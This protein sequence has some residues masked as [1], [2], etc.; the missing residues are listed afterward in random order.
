MAAKHNLDQ[1]T[2]SDPRGL[3]LS[4]QSCDAFVGNCVIKIIHITF[5]YTNLG[6][7]YKLLKEKE[8]TIMD[9]SY[10]V[11]DVTNWKRALHCQIFRNS[12]E[13]SYCVT[14]ELDITNFIAKIRP[15][16][17]SF[18]MAL[19]FAVSKCANDIEE[20][21]YRFVDGQIVLYDRN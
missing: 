12:I 20:F 4:F 5:R 6:F 11:I 1:F 17:Y 16:K 8:T 14:F 15:M 18:T 19:I 21:R 7:Q 13:P 3:A 10:K 2:F 9:G